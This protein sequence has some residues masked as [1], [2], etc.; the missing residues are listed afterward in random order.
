MVSHIQHSKIDGLLLVM[1]VEQIVLR[2]L[3]MERVGVQ[4]P[5]FF[6]LQE[7]G[8]P[9]QH[10]KIDGLLLVMVLEQIV[11]RILAME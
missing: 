10:S 7:M 3:A 1:M 11:L 4:Q 2:I 5:I 9:I 6:L 8:S